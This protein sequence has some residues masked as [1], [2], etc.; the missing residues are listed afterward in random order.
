MKRLHEQGEYMLH[1][2]IMYM[3]VA[4]VTIQGMRKKHVFL[5]CNVT[6]SVKHTYTRKNMYTHKCT[7]VC[8]SAQ[9]ITNSTLWC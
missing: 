6:G 7:C 2:C 4:S 8:R 9:M 1:S 3:L 5:L